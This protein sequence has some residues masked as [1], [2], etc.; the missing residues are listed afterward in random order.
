MTEATL[1]RTQKLVLAAVIHHTYAPRIAKATRLSPSAVSVALRELR[2]LGLVSV[3]YRDR[4]GVPHRN[5][6]YDAMI[7][8][9][10]AE[11]GA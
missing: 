7:R 6:Q 10:L 4:F 8:T 9:M 2:E 1:T 5:V 11:K 3:T